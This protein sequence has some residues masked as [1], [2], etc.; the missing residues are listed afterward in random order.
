MF[1]A[2]DDLSNRAGLKMPSLCNAATM[3]IRTPGAPEES[4]TVLLDPNASSPVHAEVGGTTSSFGPAST[5]R[6]GKQD[7]GEKPRMFCIFPARNSAMLALTRTAELLATAISAVFV[8]PV[9]A[10]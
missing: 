10:F 6:G 3:F 8:L 4:V 9:W 1:P 5:I 7:G 2:K